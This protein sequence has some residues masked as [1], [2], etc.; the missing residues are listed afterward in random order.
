M[1]Y[2]KIVQDGIVIDANDVFLRFQPKHKVMLACE[3]ENAEYIQS[4]DGS[5]IWHGD[6]L[7]PVPE[8]AP[9]IDSISMKG[10]SDSDTYV[11]YIDEDEFHRIREQLY[12]DEAIIE[13]EQGPVPEESEPAEEDEPVRKSQTAEKLEHMQQTIDEL[14]ETNSMLLECIMEMSEIVYG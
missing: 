13:L 6:W 3:A 4:R 1:I 10:H 2:Y 7:H 14:L 11:V 8:C 9:E 12:E 5:T